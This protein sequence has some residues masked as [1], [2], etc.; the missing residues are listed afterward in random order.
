VSLGAQCERL[1]AFALA[2]GYEIVSLETDAGVSGKVAPQDRP[3]MSAALEM[4]RDGRADGIVSLKLDRLSRD[5]R[6]TLD[7]IEDSDR[8]G[9]RLLSVSE[10][11]DTGSAAGRLVVTVLAALSQMEREQISERT[12]FS[13]EAI[14][15]E[16]R[17]R[18]RFVPFGWRTADGGT[19]NLAGDHRELQPHEQEQAALSQILD[20]Y[21]QDGL[22]ARRIAAAMNK[23]G[24]NPRSSKAW[25]ANSVAAILRRV[26]RWEAAGISPVAA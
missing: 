26:D 12:V 25:T 15:R 16:G 5:T 18:S 4:V 11:L 9:W 13:L 22:G 23:S 6:A 24:C 7:L 19:Q 21:N 3:G 10:S 17:G 2:H 8:N 1:R 14:A 20:L